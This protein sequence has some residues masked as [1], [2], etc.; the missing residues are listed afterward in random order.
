MPPR[1]QTRD[2]RRA[3]SVSCKHDES[4]EP[5]GTVPPPPYSTSRQVPR[6]VFI[7][8]TGYRRGWAG[9]G[10]GGGGGTGGDDAPE[11]LSL[12]RCHSRRSERRTAAQQP[13]TAAVPRREPLL[14]VQPGP[15]TRGNR[16]NTGQTTG[17]N[18][19]TSGGACR[20][21]G[22][23]VVTASVVICGNEADE[24]GCGLIWKR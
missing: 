18:R 2:S 14:M 4:T 8:G 3:L 9:G 20:T 21:D 23:D 13:V 7:S 17:R 11:T 15:D 19:D 5:R 22:N 6:A 24:S 10:G 12:P 1:L 16:L